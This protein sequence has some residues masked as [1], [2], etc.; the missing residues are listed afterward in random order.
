MIFLEVVQTI[1]LAFILLMEM[2]GVGFIIK[3]RR[4]QRGRRLSSTE[5][6]RARYKASSGQSPTCDEDPL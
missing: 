6:R 1:L 3:R 4:E 5:E 2:A